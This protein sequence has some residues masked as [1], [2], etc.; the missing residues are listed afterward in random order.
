V[1][2]G[3]QRGHVH[4]AGWSGPVGDGSFAGTSASGLPGERGA[5]LAATV[6][7]VRRLRRDLHDQ[8]GRPARGHTVG[9]RRGRWERL[10]RPSA[11][12][13]ASDLAL[14][15]A[16]PVSSSP[17]PSGFD[18]VWASCAPRASVIR[19]WRHSRPVDAVRVDLGR[20]CDAVVD[21]C[22]LGGPGVADDV[23][24][25]AEAE[26]RDGFH[27]LFPPEEPLGEEPEH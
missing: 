1:P 17:S 12:L 4:S 16:C 9:D 8:L 19:L 20:D 13:L 22:L 14:Q 7:E 3:G 25:V 10:C 23:A 26:H 5:F 11:R 24:Q 6:G 27:G 21:G 2:P 15:D 18:S